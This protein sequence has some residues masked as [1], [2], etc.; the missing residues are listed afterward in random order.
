MLR[1][2][3]LAGLVVGASGAASAQSI[4]STT[5]TQTNVN[6]YAVIAPGNISTEIT[7]QQSGGNNNA[8][9]E[10]S[11]PINAAD[12]DQRAK[13]ANNSYVGQVGGINVAIVT[14][15]Y[16]FGAILGA[17]PGYS[18]QQTDIGYLSE[19]NSGGVS[20]LSLTGPGNS[21]FSSFGRTH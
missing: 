18:A 5:L 7:V 15:Q 21:V 12:V 9:L 11:G 20:I 6:N 10:Q 8:V 13:H 3:I 16:N 17:T 4:P 1:M 19:F 2:L 14:Q